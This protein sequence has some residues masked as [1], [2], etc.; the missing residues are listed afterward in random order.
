MMSTTYT[1]KLNAAE[2]A[3]VQ[4]AIDMAADTFID[5]INDNEELTPDAKVHRAFEVGQFTEKTRNMF[6]GLRLPF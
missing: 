6:P 2:M 1:V 5:M 3:M 4:A